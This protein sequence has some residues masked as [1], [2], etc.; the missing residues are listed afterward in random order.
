VKWALPV[1]LVFVRLRQLLW[2]RM[3]EGRG[4]QAAQSI[5]E[6]QQQLEK[7]LRIHILPECLWRSFTVTERNGCGPRHRDV[8]T[9]RATTADTLFRIGSTSKAFAALSIL[10]LRIR[11]SSR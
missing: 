9:N 4:T 3:S 10:M 8:A 7:I 11:A 6:L 1:V 5:A 2:Q